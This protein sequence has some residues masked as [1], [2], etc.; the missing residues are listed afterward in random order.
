[1]TNLA[2]LLEKEKRLT[3]LARECEGL[4]G[5]DELDAVRAQIAAE[6]ARA[7]RLVDGRVARAREAVAA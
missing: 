4:Q 6:I 3:A 1:M 5:L 7:A 2:W